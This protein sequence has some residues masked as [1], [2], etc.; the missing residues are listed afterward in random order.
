MD[1]LLAES[2]ALVSIPLPQ[3]EDRYDKTAKALVNK[4]SKL[5]SH[6]IAP[7]KDDLD[8]ISPSA[9][10]ILYTYMLVAGMEASAASGKA[11]PRQLP[12]TV[13]PEGALWPYIAQLLLEFD[14][15]QARYCGAQ[16]LR[17]VDCVALGAEQTANYVPAIQLLYHV[18]LR[19]DSTSSSLTST[20]RTFLRLCLL[21]QAYAEAIRIL[22]Q[23]IYHIPSSRQD[24]RTNRCLCSASDQPWN[25]LSPVTGL[26][27]PITS[28]TYLE[29]YLM[30]G[31]CYMALRRYKDAMFFFEVVL[32]APAVQNVASLIMVDAYKKWLFVGL[33]LT[34]A[35]PPMPRSVGQ[36]A[37]KHIRALSRP[38]E[39]VAEAFKGSDVEVLRAEIEVANLVWQD[40][41]NYGLAVEVFQ[42]FRKFAV[43]RLSRT[44]AA[45]SIA[46]VATR[47]SPDPSNLAETRAYVDM[48]IRNGDLSAVITDSASG[49]QTLRFLPTSAATRPEAQVESALAAQT[50]ELQMLL[51]HVQDTEHRMEISREYIDYLKKLKKVRDE[52][53][54]GKGSGRGAVDEDIDED[55][56]EEI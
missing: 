35:T 37:I 24:P 54:N 22:D 34:G 55:M 36:T 5:L 41:G 46:E 9:H 13:L 53:Q 3:E 8:A 39:A 2:S 51:K 16:F 26:S 27:Q 48:L 20:H 10:T 23:P 18:I 43:Q 1:K 50:R 47:T 38:Y 31:M 44:F 29:Y 42:A 7:S 28:R 45:M 49:A 21:S 15:V 32:T 40:D 4:L 11:P 12:S 17:I 19:L 30:G 56:M 25:F 33:L 6:E 52:K 14:P